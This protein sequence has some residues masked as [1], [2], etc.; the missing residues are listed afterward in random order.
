[1]NVL[2]HSPKL[3]DLTKGAVFQL[4]VSQSDGRKR[5][6]CSGSDFSSVWYPLLRWL[7]KGALKM[8]ALDISV[9]ASFGLYNFHT[10][11]PMRRSLFSKWS[12]FY[13]DFKNRKIIAQKGF[14][15]LDLYIW[16]NCMRFSLFWR[17]QLASAVNVLTYSPKISDLTNM[18]L[19]ELNVSQSDSRNR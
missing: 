2:T 6:R 7:L 9:T 13:V 19:F 12:T 15:F 14:C 17:K 8:D 4:K 11:Q 1:M 18:A 3:L 10:T 5:Y 16:I